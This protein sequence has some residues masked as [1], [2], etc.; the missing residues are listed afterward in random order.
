LIYLHADLRPHYPQVKM[1]LLPLTYKRPS[2]VPRDD[3]RL[4][5][6]SLGE[7][8][9]TSLRSGKSGASSGIPNALTFDKIVGGG[10][11]P[12]S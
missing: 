5:Q 7:Q 9:K 12:V 4:S 2:Y 11:C 10:T 1:G 6:S 8:E 3:A